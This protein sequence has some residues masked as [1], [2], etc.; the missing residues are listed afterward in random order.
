[1]SKVT[2][3]S[4]SS[5]KFEVPP[6]NSCCRGGG[7]QDLSRCKFT[8]RNQR[9]WTVFPPPYPLHKGNRDPREDREPQHHSGMFSARDQMQDFIYPLCHPRVKKWVDGEDIAP[10]LIPGAAP[11]PRGGRVI[12]ATLET[13][14]GESTERKFSPTF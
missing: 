11:T 2:Q 14:A 3:L 6:S 13:G 4:G 12:S 9:R 8:G 1:M 10:R 5:D 7:V